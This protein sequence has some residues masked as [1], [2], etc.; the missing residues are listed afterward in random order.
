MSGGKDSFLAALV[1]QDRGYE[2]S[3]AV[4]VIPEADS[5]MFHVPNIRLA[6]KV[7]ELIDLETEFVDEINF[8][9]MFGKLRNEGIRSV[10]SGAI[11]SDYQETRIERLCTES[12]L[13]SVAPLWRLDPFVVLNELI[14]RGIGAVIVSVAAEG[15]NDTHLGKKIDAGFVNE[16]RELAKRYGIHPC[17]EGGE[18]ES[19]VESYGNRISVDLDKAERHWEGSAGYIRI[20]TL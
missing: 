6:E 18:Y 3:R 4:A 14:L 19:I 7:A 13:I 8:D 9:S 2:I 10:I 16:L 15:L 20:R 5:M 17:G 11:A 12:D 1:A